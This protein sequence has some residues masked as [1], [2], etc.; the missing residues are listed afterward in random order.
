MPRS[1]YDELYWHYVQI[2]WIC[3]FFAS[4]VDRLLAERV[5]AGQLSDLV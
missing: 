3:S 2:I 4:S 1:I 5:S